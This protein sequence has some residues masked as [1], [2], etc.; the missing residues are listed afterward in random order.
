VPY[1][2]V[3]TPKFFYEATAKGDQGAEFVSMPHQV[4]TEVE[5]GKFDQGCKAMVSQVM[6][7]NLNHIPHMHNVT[8]LNSTIKH[9][10]LC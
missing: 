8:S 2:C 3:S 6:L 5:T 7:H 1:S 4:T 10:M 9:H